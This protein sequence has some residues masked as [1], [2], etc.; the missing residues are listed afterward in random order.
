MTRIKF[1]K[2]G[3]V[4][5]EAALDPA[6]MD[7]TMKRH[8]RRASGLNGKLVQAAVRSEISG[9]KFAPNRPLTVALKGGRN[10]PLIGNSDLF[11]AI[12]SKV[13]G[14]TQVFV[15]VLRT[16]DVY[17]IAVAIHDG[18]EIGV[19]SAMRGLFFVLWQA[20][21]DPAQVAKLKGRAKDLW[22]TM[23]GGWKPLKPSTR[24]IIIPSRPFI[25]QAFKAVGLK[26]K[27]Q[28]NWRMALQA[29]VREQSRSGGA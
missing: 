24:A 12:T 14:D 27:V 22:E 9:G 25:K 3:W 18:R 19:T 10:E 5:L 4:K 7:A 17:N 13:I 1:D 20:S 16:D 6:K 11:N 15:G 2:R 28:D 29:A 26:K 8:L 21:V 23:P